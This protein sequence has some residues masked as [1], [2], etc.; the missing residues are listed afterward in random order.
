MA[1]EFQSLDSFMTSKE[2]ELFKAI[3][4]ETK[5]IKNRGKNPKKIRDVVPIHQWVED[6]YYVGPPGMSLYPY[7]KQQLIRVFDEE[8]EVPINEVIVT[9]GIGTGKSTF[10]CFLIVRKLYELSCYTNIPALFQ[11]MPGTL[12]SFMYF[13]VSKTQAELTG[14]GQIKN[15]ID[16]IPY[17][18]ENFPRNDKLQS[19]L[20]F[21][22]DLLLFYGSSNAHAIGMNMIGSILDEANFFQNGAQNPNKSAIEYSK[23]A[24]M[25]SSIVNRSKSRFKSNKWDASLS[26]LISSNTTSASFTEKRIKEV[27]GEPNTL[28]INARVWDVKPKGTY[29]D[30]MFWVFTG[31]DLLDPYIIKGPEDV[32][33]YTDSMDMP[34][35]EGSLDE[36]IEQ[37]FIGREKFVQVPMDFYK[38]YE[39]NLIMSLQDISGLSVAPSGR[40]FSSR[41]LYNDACNTTLEHPFYKAEIMI[42]THDDVAIKDYLRR[43]YRPFRRNKKR[44][45]HIDQSTTNDSTGFASSYIDRYEKDKVTGMWKPIV[46]TDILLRITP[47]KPPR[48]ISISKVRDFIFFMRDVWQLE[49]GYVSYDSFASDESLQVLAENGIPC[50]LLSVDRTDAQ[51]LNLINLI[52]EHRLETY[53]YKP[54]EEELFELIH[55][56]GARRVDHPVDGSKDV[57]DGWAGSV[58]NAI[59][60]TKDETPLATSDVGSR[61]FVMGRDEDPYTLEELIGGY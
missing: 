46:A 13:T 6:E 4:E 18:K 48:K 50:G 41:P 29:S 25:Y 54:A 57:C 60:H 28:V 26:V 3:L 11:L 10:G 9:G 42:S 36:I 24:E 23:I 61:V 53:R 59:T 35:F 17:F 1:D 30:E 44:Y 14:Y 58:W 37:I 20:V 51:Y 55:F 22:E 5:K 21:P 7:W 45:I 34:R 16:S 38:Q 15:I 52:Y 47:P 43:D 27:E 39:D 2:M 40:L 49:I 8:N 56:R 31:S 32:Y 33:L 19:M 12:I